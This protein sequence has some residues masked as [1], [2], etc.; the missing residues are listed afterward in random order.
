MLCTFCAKLGAQRPAQKVHSVGRPAEARRAGANCLRLLSAFLECAVDVLAS[1]RLYISFKSWRK[2]QMNQNWHF[3]RSF[4]EIRQFN[5]RIPPN[6]NI[7]EAIIIYI[8]SFIPEK[9][10]FKIYTIIMAIVNS[11][12]RITNLKN[13]IALRSNLK[14]IVNTNAFRDF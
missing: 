11:Y 13:S 5:K 8:F 9:P 7:Q 12:M 14:L 6:Y 1:Y 2:N 3:D 10:V 4:I